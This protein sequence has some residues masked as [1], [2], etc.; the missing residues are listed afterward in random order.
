MLLNN[1]ALTQLDDL[2]DDL[3]SGQI[4]IRLAGPGDNMPSSASAIY[5]A[6]PDSQS[7]LPG[8]LVLRP[9]NLGR[10]S[11]A[12]VLSLI[13]DLNHEGRHHS[14]LITR[15][16]LDESLRSGNGLAKDRGDAYVR[17]WLDDETASRLDS[18][19]LRKQIMALPGSDYKG[20]NT[21][22]L[23]SNPLYRRFTE[24][25][26]E[27][28]ALG[29]S[30][31]VRTQHLIENSR[32][33]MGAYSDHLY[34]DWAA[35]YATQATKMNP[36]EAA[37]YLVH[38]KNTFHSEGYS[39]ES[40]TYDDGSSHVWIRHEGGRVT[41]YIYDHSAYRS[42]R[43]D[44][45][46]NGDQTRTDY[47]AS[48]EI[49]RIA[50]TDGAHDNPDYSTRIQAFDA[51]GRPD[52][53][54]VWEDDGAYTGY[55]YDQANERGD[56][57]WTIH[58]DSQGRT[59]WIAIYEDDGGYT[60]KDYDQNNERGDSIWSIRL[61]KFGRKDWNEVV[62]DDG[63]RDWIDYDQGNARNDS[64]WAQHFDAGGRIDW[65]DISFDDGGRKWVDHDQSN[66]RV[67]S[68]WTEYF[69]ASGR[70]DWRDISLDDGGRNWT[71]FDQANARVDSTWAQRFDASGRLDWENI[72]YD[73]G[74]RV[75]VD[76]DQAN[77][78]ALSSTRHLYDASGREDSFADFYDDG[79]RLEVDLDETGANSWSSWHHAF[80]QWGR[81]SCSNEFND[82]GR[83]FELDYDEAGANPW[84]SCQT[85]FDA[86]ARR[87]YSTRFFDDGTRLFVDYDHYGLNSHKLT[88]F[89]ALGRVSYV[90]QQ[91]P[92]GVVAHGGGTWN[93]NYGAGLNA[94]LV[95]GNGGYSPPSPP[96]TLLP[97]FAPNQPHN[98]VETF[99]V[100]WHDIE[101]HPLPPL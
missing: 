97:S 6:P 93:P 29:L 74:R 22:A 31:Q 4:R 24:L 54:A 20:S 15:E 66:V 35:T 65:Q 36:K 57:I 91:L 48:D 8:Y 96:S 42:S 63:G 19:E 21:A 76:V 81:L 78:T 28:D 77:A 18:Y 100:P 84:S 39:I 52:S 27:A 3:V 25:S 51:H 101:A 55:D 30:G 37:A 34:R 47:Y 56:S 87:D 89:D 32:V 83:R 13:D 61:D 40:Q 92:S 33:E 67:D 60:G 38:A 80:D 99:P 49:C 69:D 88:A 82:D 71:D 85:M 46:A 64:G 2:R 7:G 50:D 43:I 53:L 9:E 58:R 72:F 14:N 1:Q 26:K 23:E 73:D 5:V 95:L 41:E 94:T 12:A 11:D 75:L 68:V 44:T 16:Q 86:N 90:G 45:M 79:S 10:S 17:G 59:D 70:I 62:Q 98:D